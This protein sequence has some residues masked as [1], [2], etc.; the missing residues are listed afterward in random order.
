VNETR[1]EKLREAGRKRQALIRELVRITGCE[2][3]H[4]QM[5]LSDLMDGTDLVQAVLDGAPGAKDAFVERLGRP[6]LKVFVDESGPRRKVQM[7][8]PRTDS[9][10]LQIAMWFIRKVGGLE[11]AEKTFKAARAALKVMEQ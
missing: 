9:E 11:Q 8:A 6:P 2:H 5:R 1:K 7:E 3:S 4:I 10:K